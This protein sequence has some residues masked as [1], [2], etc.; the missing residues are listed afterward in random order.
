LL[1]KKAVY[2]RGRIAAV[3]V[4]GK[5]SRMCVFEGEVGLK[6]RRVKLE[7]SLDNISR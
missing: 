5:R 7:W 4:W 1:P 6:R 2:E 3:S